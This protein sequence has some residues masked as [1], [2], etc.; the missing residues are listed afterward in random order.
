MRLVVGVLA[1]LFLVGGCETIQ[2]RNHTVRQASTLTD[3]QY[4]EVLENFAM[5]AREPDT[6]PFFVLANKGVTTIQ[7]TETAT[8]GV[9][10]DYV[11]FGA[12]GHFINH[13][14][15]KNL[16]LT[17]TQQDIDTWN[18]D[19]ILDPDRLQ[20]MRRAYQK[21]SGTIAGIPVVIRF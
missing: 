11:F 9:N 5:F 17:G 16:A 19:S 13:A 21:R 20:L 14:D 4:E 2:L 15:K 8:G 12:V 7:Q 18:T 10:W 6:V 1:S 3:M